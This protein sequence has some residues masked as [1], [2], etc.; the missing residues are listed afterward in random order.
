[1]V[2]FLAMLYPANYLSICIFYLDIGKVKFTK[3]DTQILNSFNKITAA[4]L[5][6][7][8][9]IFQYNHVFLSKDFLVK[10]Y[11]FDLS[12][13]NKKKTLKHLE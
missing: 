9:I 7:V 1:M 8:Y 6:N 10:M 3:L 11:F 4:S 2:S 13:G 5:W 12:E